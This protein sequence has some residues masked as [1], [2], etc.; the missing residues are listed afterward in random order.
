M[1]NFVVINLKSLVKN[2]VKV[3]F[4]FAFIIGIMNF[5]KVFSSTSKNFNYFKVLEKTINF[6]AKNENQKIFLSTISQELAISNRKTINQLGIENA[7]LD[8]EPEKDEEVSIA[9]EKVKEQSDIEEIE[10]VT[11]DKTP[12]STSVIQANNL[13][14][15]YN[16]VYEDIKIKNETS[17]SLS[18]E[19]LNPSID[20][21]D[22]T[23]IIIFHT[24]T[25]ES[26]TQT[27]ENSYIASRKLQ[28]NR[29]ELLCSK[30]WELFGR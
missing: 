24:H 16:T 15:N 3:L 6:Q 25:C 17:F 9:D 29:F 14:E 30:G 23:N 22:K 13:A 21:S 20:F 27:Q 8:Y 1:I 2:S 18:P 11:V 5:G 4:I 26:Y 19:I 10:E 12:I 28:N 7:E